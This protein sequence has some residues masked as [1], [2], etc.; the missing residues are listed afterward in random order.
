MLLAQEKRMVEAN[1]LSLI[2]TDTK[3]W[4][5]ICRRYHHIEE[6][7]SIIKENCIDSTIKVSNEETCPIPPGEEETQ[8][9]FDW[10]RFSTHKKLE[11]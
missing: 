4:C 2:E 6:I 1:N 3:I 10:R 8:S 11:R 7:G 9:H 5:A